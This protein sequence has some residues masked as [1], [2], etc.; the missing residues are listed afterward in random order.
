[1]IISMLLV[2]AGSLINSLM[3]GFSW[4]A[5]ATAG[6]LVLEPP[7]EL[8]LEAA[9]ELVR[10][11]RGARSAA[12]SWAKAVTVRQTRQPRADIILFIA[13]NRIPIRCFVK[14]GHRDPGLEPIPPHFAGALGGG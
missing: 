4:S 6:A 12:L 3:S 11:D 1:M 2:K 9:A 13:T 7:V 8:V 5:E 10:G 14:R